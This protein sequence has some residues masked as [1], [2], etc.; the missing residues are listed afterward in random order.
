[1]RFA[2]PLPNPIDEIKKRASQFT[3]GVHDGVEEFLGS[4]P[5]PGPLTKAAALLAAFVGTA[6]F[7]VPVF[8]ILVAYALLYYILKALDKLLDMAGIEE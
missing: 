1:M 4:A 7:I 8:E 5:D 3:R 6:I 2:E